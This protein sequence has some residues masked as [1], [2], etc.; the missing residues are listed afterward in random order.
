MIS[1]VRNEEERDDAIIKINGHVWK[2]RTLFAKVLIGLL[3][4]VREFRNK[5]YNWNIVESGIKHHQTN[6]QYTCMTEFYY[7]IYIDVSELF[8]MR[9]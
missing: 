1:L 5:G 8:R 2:D 4:Y 6:K 7:L 3:V 9:T